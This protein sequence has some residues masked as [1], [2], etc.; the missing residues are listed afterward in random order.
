LSVTL[1][2]NQ[3]IKKTTATME[4]ATLMTKTTSTIGKNLMTPEKI[5][6]RVRASNGDNAIE[7]TIDMICMVFV[8]HTWQQSKH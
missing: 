3:N 4:N 5:V 2:N 7:N 1:G 8:R 6:E